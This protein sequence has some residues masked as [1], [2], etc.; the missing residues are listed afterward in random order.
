M[1]KVQ[2]VRTK[3]IDCISGKMIFSVHSAQSTCGLVMRRKTRLTKELKA[4]TQTY[5]RQMTTIGRRRSQGGLGV[6]ANRAERKQLA[7]P[8]DAKPR[9][10]SSWAKFWRPESAAADVEDRPRLRLGRN[11]WGGGQNKSRRKKALADDWLGPEHLITAK[12]TPIALALTSA[13]TLLLSPRF[14]APSSAY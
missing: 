12:W 14:L 6:P 4:T 7:R 2:G 1:T 11:G 5:L 10:A 3:G 8:S 9:V 13:W